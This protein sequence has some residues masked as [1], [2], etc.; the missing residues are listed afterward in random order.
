MAKH[1]KM[2]YQTFSGMPL[3]RIRLMYEHL[4]KVMKE[5]KE[6]NDKLEAQ[7]KSKSRS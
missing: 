7:M 2:D 5:E 3:W 1:A 4:E 6:N